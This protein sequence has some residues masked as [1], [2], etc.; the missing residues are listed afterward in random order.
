MLL[1]KK[2]LNF[3]LKTLDKRTKISFV[4]FFLLVTCVAFG[5]YLTI[6][7]SGIFAK[8][9]LGI[10][11]SENVKTVLGLDHSFI[12]LIL[13]IFTNLGRALISYFGLR[14]SFLSASQVCQKVYK[15]YLLQDYLKY[16]SI[17]SS[18]LIAIVT[19]KINTL[20]TDLI[21]PLIRIS[22]SILIMIF[23]GISILIKAP[24]R[25]I[26]DNISFIG[27]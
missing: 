23:I 22:S 6:G 4:F 9:L 26:F 8:K 17:N 1:K 15:N 16:L 14:L 19:T 24:L 3:I 12:F 2:D 7:E 27:Y 20:A 10:D 13:I 25:N 21:L 11:S 5:E 18:E